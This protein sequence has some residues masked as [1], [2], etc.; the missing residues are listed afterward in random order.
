MDRCHLYILDTYISKLLNGA[1][2]KDVFYL[3]PRTITPEDPSDPQ[4]S[5]S[6]FLM[7]K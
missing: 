6:Y 4:I 7:Q 5:V 2:E 1:K 3:K